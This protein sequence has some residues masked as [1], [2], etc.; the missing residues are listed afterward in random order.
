MMVRMADTDKRIETLART[1][2]KAI[3]KLAK[4]DSTAAQRL[5]AAAQQV[6]DDIRAGRL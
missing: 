1:L 3:A 5:S 2:G 6:V 4:T